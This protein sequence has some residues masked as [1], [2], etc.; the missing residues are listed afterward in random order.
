ME[1]AKSSSD[2]TSPTKKFSDKYQILYHIESVP[3]RKNN[4]ISIYMPEHVMAK[5]V[6]TCVDTGLSAAKVLAISSQP[7]DCCRGKNVEVTIDG[8]TYE[9]QRG[10][11]TAK[12]SNSG[13]KIHEKIRGNE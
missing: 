4:L 12:R 2:N 8:V 1:D 5:V 10:L 13:M 7:C 9:I 11:F 3:I 6:R